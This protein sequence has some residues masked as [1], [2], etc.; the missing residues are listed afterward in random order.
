D[1]G[2]DWVQDYNAAQGDVL[3]IGI[4][5]ATASQFHVN[6]AHTAT[7]AGER[8]G[9]DNVEEA[10]VIYRP[11]GQIVWALVDGAGQSEITLQIAGVNY[12][13]LV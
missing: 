12:D 5:T 1:H 9:D 6:T 8:S 7:A 2:S 13:L 11:T 3:E 10:F 4:A